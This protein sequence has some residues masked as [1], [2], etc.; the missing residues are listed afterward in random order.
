M[1]KDAI[2]L[3][4]PVMGDNGKL[5]VPKEL[6]S[7]YREEVIRV[8]DILTPNQFEAELLTGIKVTTEASALRA[9]DELHAR[10]P[11]VIVLT[12]CA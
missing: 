1:N 3:C 7:I 6:V 4:D 11:K 5:Y 10:G 9:F 2:Y 8:A 12:R